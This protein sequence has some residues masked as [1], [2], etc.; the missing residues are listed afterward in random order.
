MSQ[1]PAQLIAAL[2]LLATQGFAAEP[3]RVE[4]KNL[5]VEFNDAMH[6]RLVAVLGGQERVVGDFAP[7]ESI[8]VSGKGIEDFALQ[9]QTREPIRDRLGAGFRTVLTGTA[10]SLK[11]TVI[12]TMYD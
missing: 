9:K 10:S 8:R 2:A 7:S 3:V 6:S 12:V 1:T 11:K 5:R 4:G